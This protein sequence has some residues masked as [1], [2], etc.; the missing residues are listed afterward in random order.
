MPKFEIYFYPEREKRR[1][2]ADA[3]NEICNEKEK[4][5]ILSKLEMLALLD[6]RE[7]PLKWKKPVGNFL[8]FKNGDFRLLYK[9]Q[10]QKIIIV[11]A[12]RKVSQKIPQEEFECAENNWNSYLER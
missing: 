2:P 9:I 4:A 11:H 3:L 7:R 12:F 8:E 10:D 1:S 5:Q 6:V